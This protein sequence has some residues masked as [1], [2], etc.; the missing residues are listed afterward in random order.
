MNK[1]FKFIFALVLGLFISAFS[2]GAYTV[3]AAEAA[4]ETT[5]IE[6]DEVARAESAESAESADDSGSGM[7]LILGGM[8]LIILVVVI[9]VISSVFSV[10]PIVDE[11]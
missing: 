5:I 10:V 6:N 2:M 4:Q 3:Q 11:L 8:L 1:T 9:S 7:I